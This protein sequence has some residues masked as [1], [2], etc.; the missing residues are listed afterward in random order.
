MNLFFL[1]DWWIKMLLCNIYIFFFNL[2]CLLIIRYFYK[3][4]R[5]VWKKGSANDKK[6][7]QQKTRDQR[8]LMSQKEQCTACDL[9]Y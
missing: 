3:F 4:S 1:N 2:S 9:F 7:L 6:K 8:E 5:K